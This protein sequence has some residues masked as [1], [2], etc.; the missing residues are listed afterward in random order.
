LG[1]DGFGLIMVSFSACTLIFLLTDYGF[2]LSAPYWIA[3]NRDYKNRV[4]KYIGAIFLIKL[5]ILSLIGICLFIYVYFFTLT[6]SPTRT[7]FA[8]VYL[9]AIA[10]AFQPVWL[11]QGIEKMKSVTIFMVTAKLA[12][13]L[14]VFIFIKDHDDANMVLFCFFI[15]NMAATVIA[16]I[17]LYKT[18]Y[19]IRKPTWHIFIK[20]LYSSSEFFLSRLAVGAYTNASTLIVGAVSGVIQ[21]GLYSSAEKLYQAGQNLTSPVSQA[22]YPYVARTGDKNILIKTI[23]ILFIPLAI[24]CGVCFLYAGD[25]LRLIY[26]PSFVHAENLLHVFLL[27][28]LITFVSINL[29]YPIFAAIGKVKIANRTVFVG[30]ILQISLLAIIYYMGAINAMN[31]AL[32]VLVTE[33]I[34]LILRLGLF[35]KLKATSK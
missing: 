3:N 33:S 2:N 28:S 24:G 27:L 10:Q 13:L 32:S 17:L 11:F 31:V 12:Y 4:S 1:I 7:L 15:S 30:G 5:I 6:S 18:G 29:G 22:L 9:V 19:S 25:I 21:A 23:V 35:L 26:G 14:L 8:L 34:V 20:T 16:N